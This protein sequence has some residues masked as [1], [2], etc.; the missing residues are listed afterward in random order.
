MLQDDLWRVQASDLVW[1]RCTR[2]VGPQRHPRGESVPHVEDWRGL[3]QAGRRR[4]HRSAGWSRFKSGS[5]V[6]RIIT[7]VTEALNLCDS[8][9]WRNPARPCRLSYKAVLHDCPH[10][11]HD[12]R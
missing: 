2:C 3:A 9:E 11:E 10:D 12:A 7:E 6:R 5:G 8:I 1:V 4:D